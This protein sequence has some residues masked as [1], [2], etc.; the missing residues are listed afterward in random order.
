MAHG[1]FSQP[2]PW[3][4]TVGARLART[5]GSTE[6]PPCYHPQSPSSN[7]GP[8]THRQRPRQQSHRFHHPR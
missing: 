2:G 1:A 8:S 4:P 5:L 3:R 7:H 6:E